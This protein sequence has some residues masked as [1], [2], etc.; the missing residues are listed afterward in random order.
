MTPIVS[1]GWLSERI[2]DPMLRVADCRWYLGEPLRGRSTYGAG[3]IP[4]AVFVDLETDLSAAE[5]P[6]RHPLPLPADFATRLG[7]LGI[8]NRHAVVAY[9][10]RGGAIA[11]RLWRMLTALGHEA[12][13]VLDG[14]LQAWVAHGGATT[15]DTAEPEQAAYVTD[16]VAW[17]GTVDRLQLGRRLGTVDLIDAR[18]AN[19]FVGSEEPIDP[20]AGH[21]PTARNVP[22][23][24]NLTA[25]GRFADPSLL[26]VRYGKGDLPPVVYCGSGVTACHDILAMEI[27]GLGRATLYPGSWSDWSSNGGAVETGDPAGN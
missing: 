9:D 12:A 1:A 24:G 22:Q 3:H 2:D 5:G 10:D 7:R 26:A 4:G 8:G 6:G 23:E 27:A 25:D 18:A 16:S 11:S 20:V 14:G 13:A 17:P 21:I 19:R 15:T